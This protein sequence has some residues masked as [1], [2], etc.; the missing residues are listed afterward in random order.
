MAAANSADQKKKFFRRVDRNARDGS[1]GMSASTKRHFENVKRKMFAFVDRQQTMEYDGMQLPPP[2]PFH[3]HHHPQVFVDQKIAPKPPSHHRTPTPS[4]QHLHTPVPSRQHL[5]TPVP[6][7]KQLPH[8]AL[9][10]PQAARRGG[11][12]GDRL[13]PNVA[14]F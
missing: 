4:R 3:R 5:Q 7:H 8:L 14:I 12:F 11:K 10:T 1:S 13:S 6:S 2:L 9:A